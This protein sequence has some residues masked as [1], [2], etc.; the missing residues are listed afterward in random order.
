MVVHAILWDLLVVD[1]FCM[2]GTDVPGT[3]GSMDLL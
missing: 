3:A 2:P 1:V